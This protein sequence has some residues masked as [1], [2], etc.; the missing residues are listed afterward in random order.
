MANVNQLLQIR[1][2]RAELKALNRDLDQFA[3]RVGNSGGQ[4][5]GGWGRKFKE[6]GLTLLKE[7]GKGAAWAVGETLVKR[8]FER[9]QASGR[10]FGKGFKR[11]AKREMETAGAE[12]GGG[13]GSGGGGSG[14]GM[15]LWKGVAISAAAVGLVAGKTLVSS[16]REAMTQE[17][18]TLS[19]E[20]LQPS[21]GTRIFETLRQ[22]AL[23][24]GI[25]ITDMADNVRKFLALGFDETGAMKLN[26]AILDVAGGMG[27]TQADANGLGMALTQIAAK[28]TAAMEELR[29]Q[30]AERGVPIFDLLA[31]KLNVTQA[32][33][34]KMITAGKVSADTVIEAFSNL[35]GPL[36]RFAG[37]ADRMGKSGAGLFARFKQELK[38]WLRLLGENLLPEIKPLLEDAIGLVERL[39][40]NAV[41][42]GATLAE[43]IGYLRAGLQELSMGEIFQLAGLGLKQ[44]F[45][46]ALDVLARGLAAIFAAF[47]RQDF[48]VG[49]EQR[50]KDAGLVFKEAMLRGV[51]EAFSVMGDE[52]GI[53]KATELSEAI[54]RRADAAAWN[55]DRDAKLQARRGTAGYDPLAILKEEFDQARS[56]FGLSIEDQAAFDGLIERVKRRRR[57]NRAAQ[58]PEEAAPPA[59]TTS[60]APA[61]KAPFDPQ[62]LIGGGIANALSLIGGGGSTV[63][64]K[65]QVDLAE[66]TVRKQNEMNRTL[67]E[68]EKNT[69]PQPQR[70]PIARR[71]QFT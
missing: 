8:F 66:Q 22:D 52:M 45:L 7:F 9:G 17:T 34:M 33:L 24:T 71:P 32:E 39:K 62:A 14:F 29:G 57:E 70:G 40:E 58:T 65:K 61:G 11:S 18:L 35:E 27:L 5:G 44:A 42:F 12:L 31:T 43:A 20:A 55:R 36:A 68:I 47:Q 3:N 48:L 37:G 10:S 50:L 69:R 38:D 1:Q 26:R 46:T 41:A 25:D 56:M 64:L 28:G 54:G 4:A 53:G 49:I 30:I 21:G 13:G 59:A 19:L 63:I 51:A 16:I 15:G 2:A 60:A 67:A 23:R 6:A